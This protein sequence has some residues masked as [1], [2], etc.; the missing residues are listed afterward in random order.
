[1]DIAT[2][3]LVWGYRQWQAN[4][5][6]Q[7]LHVLPVLPDGTD[8]AEAAAA[9]QEAARSQ[10]RSPDPAPGFGSGVL[11]EISPDLSKIPIELQEVA[12]DASQYTLQKLMDS[13]DIERYAP[14]YRNA[15]LE[16]ISR[17]T[18]E[19]SVLG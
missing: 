2:D 17:F 14:P 1:M 16:E 9:A 3:V 13:A 12:R 7:A 19:S 5:P 10:Y 8:P 18:D 15:D 4:N 11:R 6:K